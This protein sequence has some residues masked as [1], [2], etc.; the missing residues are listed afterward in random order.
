L[1]AAFGYSEVVD[2]DGFSVQATAA[3]V[4]RD[5][6]GIEPTTDALLDRLSRQVGPHEVDVVVAAV[7]RSPLDRRHYSLAGIAA[8]SLAIDYLGA[9][10]WHEP[11][12]CTNTTGEP[13][14]DRS[15]ALFLRSEI[16]STSIDS[17][18]SYPGEVLGNWA[19]DDVADHL[20]EPPVAY[21]DINSRQPVDRVPAPPNSRPGDRLLLAWDPGCRI[22][23][24]V[25]VRDTG[26]LGTRLDGD[27]RYS[28]TADLWWN[29]ATATEP[30][31]HQLPGE[32]TR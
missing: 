14:D 9:S 15:P 27:L 6:L 10:W 32:S 18:P 3:E 17:E 1:A 29:W 23:A 19:A 21:V 24:V 5:A 11:R 20:W 2:A 12:K 8:A 28:P 16:G 26:T 7:R 31:P 25:E 22:E 30:G 4:V 13:G